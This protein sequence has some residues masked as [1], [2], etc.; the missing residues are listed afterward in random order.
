MTRRMPD[1]AVI[2]ARRLR[3]AGLTYAEI[4]AIIPGG[5]TLNAVAR[6]I[7]F[8]LKPR[9]VRPNKRP[10]LPKPMGR[11]RLVVVSSAPTNEQLSPW[12]IDEFGCMSRRLT[13]PE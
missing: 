6:R 8:D 12:E 1:K 13:N 5:F 9:Q 3:Q 10:P 7:K 2:E 4:A 11:P